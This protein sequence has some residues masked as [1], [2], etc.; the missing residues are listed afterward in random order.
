ML[1]HTYLWESSSLRLL[2]HRFQTLIHSLTHSLVWDFG[3]RW[4]L[5]G[6]SHDRPKHKHPKTIGRKKPS[7]RPSYLTYLRSSM[8][9]GSCSVLYIPNLRLPDQGWSPSSSHNWAEV[10]RGDLQELSI[11]GSFGR[12][13]VLHTWLI[14]PWCLRLNAE[15]TSGQAWSCDLRNPNLQPD[16]EESFSRKKHAWLITTIC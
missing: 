13:L 5:G 4:G 11:C 2:I 15:W 9:I 14:R 16:S 3:P 12:I 7:V 8:N 10:S 1:V 6:G